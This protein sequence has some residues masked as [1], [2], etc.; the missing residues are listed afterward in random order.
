MFVIV[1]I[2]R[3]DYK[4]AIES[5]QTAIKIYPRH[6]NALN[7]LQAVRAIL[8]NQEGI[9]YLKT[10]N[11]AS[12]SSSFQKAMETDPG[13]TAAYNN[14][15]ALY[16]SQKQWQQAIGLLEKAKAIDPTDQEI[17]YNLSQAKEAMG[18]Q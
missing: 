18:K 13:N 10:G 14:L 5:F 7:N 2:Q 15:A 6:F 4:S 11:T 16:L 8:L 9:L 3:K 17:L 12:A 1:V